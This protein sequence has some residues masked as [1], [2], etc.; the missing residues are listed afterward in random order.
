MYT[1]SFSETCAEFKQKTRY[2]AYSKY[3]IF[4]HPCTIDGEKKS[5][6]YN[7]GKI[8][9]KTPENIGFFDY[10]GDEDTEGADITIEDFT[11]PISG[12]LR[13]EIHSEDFTHIYVKD[14][15]NLV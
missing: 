7:K 3:P 15:G 6:R 1:K 12:D 14:L 10:E 4:Y 5:S 8:T 9:W 2:L 13:F 11:W